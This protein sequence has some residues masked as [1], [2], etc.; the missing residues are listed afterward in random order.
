MD[1]AAVSD[2]IRCNDNKPSGI[3][4]QTPQNMISKKP[5][6]C[7]IEHRRLSIWNQIEMDE[8]S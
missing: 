4:L 8:L 3:C 1:N 2:D 7:S 6:V 5:P